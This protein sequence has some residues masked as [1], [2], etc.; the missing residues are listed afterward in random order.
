MLCANCHRVL[1]AGVRE[2]ERQ[3][4][5]ILQNDGTREVAAA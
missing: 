2:L 5:V 3:I 4:S 1:H